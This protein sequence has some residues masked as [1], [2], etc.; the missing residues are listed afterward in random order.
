MSIDSGARALSLILD[1]TSY[2]FVIVRKLLDPLCLSFFFKK[3]GNKIT[4]VWAKG[5]TK[6][7][8]LL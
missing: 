5:L 6:P 3:W 7:F 4:Y 1:A 2:C 8:I